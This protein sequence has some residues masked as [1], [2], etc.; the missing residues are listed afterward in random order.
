VIYGGIFFISS[1]TNGIWRSLCSVRFETYQ[2]ALVME[3]RTFDWNRWSIFVFDGL[4]RPQSWTPYVQIGFR[5]HL[6]TRILFSRES[7]D[8]LPGSHDIC[9]TFRF[10][11]WRFV[12]M[13]FCVQ[14]CDTYVDSA[15]FMLLHLSHITLWCTS[16]CFQKQPF[17]VG[18]GVSHPHTLRSKSVSKEKGL[19]K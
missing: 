8:S 2:G 17:W 13:C 12:L 6:Y 18:H 7:L 5:M 10:R 9:C 15:L 16:I 14:K 4:V 11:C 19:L 3:R 1:V